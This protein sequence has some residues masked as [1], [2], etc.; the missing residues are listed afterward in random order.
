MS[1]TQLSEALQNGFV[2]SYGEIEAAFYL[3]NP[4]ATF[5]DLEIFMT[6]LA[7]LLF[8]ANRPLVFRAISDSL[9]MVPEDWSTEVDDH[10]QDVFVHLL[11]NPQ[12]LIGLLFPARAK[13]STTLF[14]LTKSRMRAVRAQLCDRHRII[15]NRLADFH[16]TVREIADPPKP[17]DKE[18]KLQAA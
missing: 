3:A 2:S 5:R 10:A 17:S 11:Q 7:A 14:A 15:S 18:D 9:F 12:K 1:K 13:P 16:N 6:E 4:Q 8:Q